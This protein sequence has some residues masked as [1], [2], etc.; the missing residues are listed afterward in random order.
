MAQA[1]GK[2]K[3]KKNFPFSSYP[4]FFIKKKKKQRKQKYPVLFFLTADVS[5]CLVAPM[6]CDVFQFVIGAS[7]CEHF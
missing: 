7:F 6:P 4:Q 2:K 1:S 5:I 3:G